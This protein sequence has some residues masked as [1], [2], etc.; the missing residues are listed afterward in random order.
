MPSLRSQSLPS[1]VQSSRQKSCSLTQRP[2]PNSYP[3]KVLPVPISFGIFPSTFLLS[4]HLQT[5]PGQSLAREKKVIPKFL[6]DYEDDWRQTTDCESQTPA[7]TLYVYWAPCFVTGT[8]SGS[9][10]TNRGR[11]P[12]PPGGFL[13]MGPS[14]I[15]CLIKLATLQLVA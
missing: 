13:G 15:L 7:L 9:I 4:W 11:I 3:E 1:S 5:I 6:D 12:G 10:I 14:H 2:P 8:V